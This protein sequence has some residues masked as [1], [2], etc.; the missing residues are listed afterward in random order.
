MFGVL[1]F[2]QKTFFFT[3]WPLDLNV[4]FVKGCERE[5]KKMNGERR[6]KKLNGRRLIAMFLER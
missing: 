4:V 3:S 2:I 5:N 1:P 6:A